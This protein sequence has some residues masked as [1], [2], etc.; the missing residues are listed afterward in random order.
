[1]RLLFPSRQLVVDGERDAFLEAI[2]MVGC[3]SDNVTG[4]LEPQGNVKILA[5]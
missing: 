1:M 5:N 2:A 3:T 4:N